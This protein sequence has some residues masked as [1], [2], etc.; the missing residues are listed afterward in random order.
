MSPEEFRASA[1]EEVYA[2]VD[3]RLA[4]LFESPGGFTIEPAADSL[5]QRIL[6]GEW[7]GEEPLSLVGCLEIAA[8]NSR[9][10]QSRKEQLYLAALD[11]SYERWRFARRPFAS[12]GASVSGGEEAE[13]AR[14]DGEAGF[15]QLLGSGATVVADVGAELLRIVSTGDGWDLVTDLGISITQPLLAG[16][17]RRIVMESL[18]QAERNLLYETRAFERFRRTFAVDVAARVYDLLQADDQLANEEQN[19]RDL[20]ALRE[21]N[22]ALSQAGRLS[23]VEADQAKQDE[24]SSEVRL[25]SLRA[26]LERQRDQFG[27]FLGLPVGVDLPLDPAEFERLSEVDELLEKILPE[28]AVAFA[29][30]ARLDHHTTLDRLED[31]Q[32]A[33]EIAEDAL[34]AGLSLQGDIGAESADGRPLDYDGDG[35]GWSTSLSLELPLDRKQERNNYRSRLIALDA[36]Q[37]GATEAADRICANVR[38]ALRVTT[39]AREDYLIQRGAVALAERRVESTQLKLDAGRASTRDVLDSQ[40]SLVST[41]NALTSALIGFTLARLDLYLEL[42]LL[43]IDPSGITIEEGLTPALVEE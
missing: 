5:R 17:G 4:E 22:E 39:N 20:V 42:E 27:L 40:R 9:E 28:R 15:T 12:L 34:R 18:T 36:E 35:L 10:F 16:S 19:Y 25:L 6:R 8:E 1:D 37:R 31:R 30:E 13:T 43:R 26:N 41:R 23:D 21:R 29:L 32:R 24:L 11:L 2:L 38:D 3:A 14:A 33:V 7:R